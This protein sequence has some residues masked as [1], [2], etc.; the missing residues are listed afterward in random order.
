MSDPYNNNHSMGDD[1]FNPFDSIRISQTLDLNF[2]FQQ[3]QQA[4]QQQHQ[5]NN[6]NNNNN[7]NFLNQSNIFNQTNS[8][9]AQPSNHPPT[10][11]NNTSPTIT[12][13]TQPQQSITF[14]TNNNTEN[15]IVSGDIQLE[16]KE[17]LTSLETLA[18]ESVTHI[19][20]L[21]R[22]LQ[23]HVTEDLR[24]PLLSKMFSDIPQMIPMITFQ[25]FLTQYYQDANNHAFKLFMDFKELANLLAR[26]SYLQLLHLTNNLIPPG[27][28]QYQFNILLKIHEYFQ[29]VPFEKLKFFNTSLDGDSSLNNTFYHVQKIINLDSSIPIEIIHF[30]AGIVSL[31][32][33]ELLLF[34]QW[35]S[36]MSKKMLAVLLA[37]LQLDSTTVLDI[38]RILATSIISN[39]PPLI[40]PNPINSQSNTTLKYSTNTN[41]ITPTFLNSN[42]NFQQNQ[43]HNNNTN[44]NTNLNSPSLISSGY[45]IQPLFPNLTNSSGLVPNDQLLSSPISS[46]V[47]MP[48]NE[49]STPTSHHNIHSHSHSHTQ[50]HSHSQQQQQ[51]QHQLSSQPISH[52]QSSSNILNQPMTPSNNNNNNNSGLTGPDAYYLKIARQ[53]PSSTVYQR[54]LKPFPSIMLCG[55]N[56]ENENLSNYFVEAT[57][58]RNDNH[59]E[60]ANFLDG[61]KISRISNGTFAPFKKLKILT[62]SQQQRTL[63]RLKFVLK[64]YV[65]NDFQSFPNAV[66]LSDPVEVFSHTIYLTDKQ[67]VPLPPSITEIIPSLG[68]LGTRVVVLGSNF[69]KSDDLKVS[70]NGHCVQAQ[71]YEKGTIICH[72]PQSHELLSNRNLIVKVTNDGDQFSNESV[73]FTIL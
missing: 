27:T 68:P 44:N 21:C 37:L 29:L 18:Q 3:Q 25:N 51:Q 43:L 71:F 17:L 60:I 36:Q 70:F 57:L 6:V 28:P 34:H 49:P 48:Y 12:N 19:F 13:T 46:P 72:V 9:L 30:I 58:L 40:L 50:H 67:D 53:P 32:L 35:F 42:N 66:V 2:A 65:G 52:I 47:Q 41:Q 69:S 45:S 62:T 56:V 20:F 73:T 11:N 4:N 5:I 15:L 63:F 39:T 64:R 16:L 55:P 10:L 38:K 33:N 8:T 59:A 31:P 26:I 7:S 23:P 24:F 14:N 54:I 22:V 61:N 1:N